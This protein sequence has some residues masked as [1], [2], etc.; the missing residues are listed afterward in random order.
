MA[1]K[2]VRHGL[3]MREFFNSSMYNVAQWFPGHMAAGL[4]NMQNKL[5]SVDCIIE[6]HDARVP[7]TGRNPLFGQTLLGIK[8][9][10]LILNKMDL[11]NLRHK[12][13]ILEAL[14]DQGIKEVIFTNCKKPDSR[15][16]KSILPTVSRLIK[17][18]DRYNRAD[19]QD[20]SAMII[21]IPNVGKSSIINALRAKH[22]RRGRASAV[23]DTPGITRSVM[24]RIKICE[25]PKVYLIDTPGILSPQIGDV[26]TG[27]KLALVNTIKEHL[28]GEDII[29]D[30][31][32]FW[33]HSNGFSRFIGSYF[34]VEDENNIIIIIRQIMSTIN[35]WVLSVKTH[36]GY[37]KRPDITLAA[38]RFLKA[39]RTGNLGK[40]M[41]DD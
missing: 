23:G 37:E 36:N 19:E 34:D 38:T 22:L 31:L 8:P 35:N 11:T 20:Y 5:K 27:L 6:V 15:G 14:Q 41:L 10:I 3:E 33:L 28:V 1:M 17:E 25:D 29:A 40:V 7:L 4:K 16:I 26:E 12:S 30:Y 24:E 9:H 13:R 39:F 2:I 21:G 32:L 18:S